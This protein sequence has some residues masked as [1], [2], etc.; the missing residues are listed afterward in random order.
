M[1]LSHCFRVLH[2][3]AFESL[4]W[5][6]KILNLKRGKKNS[7]LILFLLDLFKYFC[8]YHIES[9]PKFWNALPKSYKPLNP[10]MLL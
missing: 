8:F 2:L 9:G 7:S 5:T 1:F 3:P 4:A 10:E 6:L